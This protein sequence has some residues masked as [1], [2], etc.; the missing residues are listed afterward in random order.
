M[1]ILSRKN[2]EAYTPSVIT[3]TTESVAEDMM[4]LSLSNKSGLL[5]RKIASDVGCDEIVLAAFFKGLG[6][7]FRS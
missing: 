1:K 6:D 5:A 3:I 2:S 4:F 7:I